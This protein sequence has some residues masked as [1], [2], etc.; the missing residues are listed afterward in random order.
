MLAELGGDGSEIHWTMIQAVWQSPAVI[1]VAPLQDLLGLGSAA[2]LNRPGRAEG[3]WGWRAEW[4]QLTPELGDRLRRLTE[5]SG[6]LAA[7]SDL[8]GAGP[9]GGAAAAARSA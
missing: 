2:R 4:R 8:P 5:R 7:S 6:R 1:A 3:N 9:A